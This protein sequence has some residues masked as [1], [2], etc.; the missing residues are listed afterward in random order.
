MH[1]Y[2]DDMAR[3]NND[4]KLEDYKE[5]IYGPNKPG[6]Q[7]P[8][9]DKEGDYLELHIG[10][11]N[12]KFW[13][14]VYNKKD[15]YEAKAVRYPTKLGNTSSKIDHRVL[16]GQIIRF[17]KLCTFYSDMLF[18]SKNCLQEML[19]NKLSKKTLFNSLTLSKRNFGQKYGITKKAFLSELFP[20]LA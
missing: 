9:S 16:L 14:K 6:I 5:E 15:N 18:C 10:I 20:G 8:N 17:E 2:V 11:R 13:T 4:N 19:D 12:N 7:N 1:R 3:I